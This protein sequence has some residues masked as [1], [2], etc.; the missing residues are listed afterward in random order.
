MENAYTAFQGFNQMK[1]GSIRSLAAATQ[2]GTLS[3]KSPI[4]SLYYYIWIFTMKHH[5][6]DAVQVLIVTGRK[7]HTFSPF[8]TINLR[9][10][11]DRS[12]H[13]EKDVFMLILLIFD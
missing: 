4:Q 6:N 3:N 5:S 7:F 10:S 2:A 8:S 9:L 1:T 12:Q 13:R 11:S